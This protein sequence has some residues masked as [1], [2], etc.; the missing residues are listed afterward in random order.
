[1]ALLYAFFGSNHVV[2]NA[3]YQRNDR[4]H[5]NLMYKGMRL[6][7]SSIP[8]AVPISDGLALSKTTFGCG[9]TLRT[10]GK[11]GKDQETR[12]GHG[13]LGKQQ[14]PSGM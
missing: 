3:L 13:F 10:F 9:G 1:M 7:T 4:R 8:K 12:Q 14:R 2:D 5:L 11:P 6:L